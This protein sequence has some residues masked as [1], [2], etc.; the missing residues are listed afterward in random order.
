MYELRAFIII[1]NTTCI[2]LK[3]LNKNQLKISFYMILKLLFEH[4][5]AESLNFF[6]LVVCLT[7][8]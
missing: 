4:T 7:I 3:K 1:R 8:E 5:N 2:G 6:E